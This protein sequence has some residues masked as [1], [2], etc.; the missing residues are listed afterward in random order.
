MAAIPRSSFDGAVAMFLLLFS[1]LAPTTT[2]ATSQSV[3]SA[4]K[5]NGSCI[6]AERDVLLSLKAGI[7]SDPSRRLTSWRGQDC[8]QW[9]GIKCSTRTGH[10][11]KLDLRNNFFIEDV[12]GDQNHLLHWLA[13]QIS[14]SLLSLYH[15]KHLDLSGNI[16]GD[17]MPIPEFIGSLK[18]LTYLNLSYMD[19]N[20]RVPP[21]LGNL[22]KLVYLD[23]HGDY[24]FSGRLYSSDLSWFA[25]LH[26][27][28]YLDMGDVNLST[29]VDWVHVVNTLANLRVAYLN[30]CELNSSISSLLHHNLTVLE[31]L[32][33][34]ENPFNSPAAPNWFWDVTSLK[35]LRI[36]RCELS[37]PFPDELGNMTML[38]GLDMYNN[39][40]KGMIPSTLT[41]LCSLQMIRLSGNDIG[42]DIEDLIERIPK[43]SWN[44]LRELHLW[45]ANITGMTLN[46]IVNLTTLSL[47]DISNNH[48]HGFVPIE[49]GTLKNLTALYIGHNNFSGVISEDH[50][51]GLTN[52]KYIDLS[53][54]HL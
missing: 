27:L 19:F 50:F 1:L 39:N 3:S 16:L 9:Y 37:G 41:N 24:F 32:D 10:V 48:L 43:C 44:N 47:L 17:Q 6:A 45:G 13:G 15:L 51:S 29:A 34:D 20:G 35:S 38:E 26:S 5:F 12:H 4:E 7:T 31:E 21:Q 53:Y 49:I 14:S 18:S 22:T 30:S 11:V 46:S 36:S 25:N 52:L 2:V 28:E 33:L 23:I 40:I 8:C 42:G 54:T